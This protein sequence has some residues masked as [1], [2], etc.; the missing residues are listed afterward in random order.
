MKR[1]MISILVIVLLTATGT[2]VFAKSPEQGPYEV[3]GSIGFGSGPGDF[4]AGFGFNFGA[5]YM[6]SSVVKNLQARI[7]IGYF[8]FSRDF[9]GSSLDF[10]RMPFTFS[11]RYYFP[12]TD[13][14]R[15]FAQAGLETSIDSKDTF[16]FLGK[17]SK[18]EVNLGLTPGGGIEFL[19]TPEIGVFAVADAHLISDSYFS[20]Q[21]GAA[22]H[23]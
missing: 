7:D 6:L 19:V 16:D 4:D 5:G 1:F 8:T 18:S 23:F 2:T 12:L 3:D 17:H 10:T 21:F 13:Q 11:A 20:M 9:F 15:V 14:L 22:Y